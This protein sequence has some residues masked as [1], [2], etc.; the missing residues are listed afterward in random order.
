MW[1]YPWQNRTPTSFKMKTR[2]TNTGNLKR[3]LGAAGNVSFL[4]ALE[5]IWFQGLPALVALVNMRKQ[6]FVLLG[7][8]EPSPG[9]KRTGQVAS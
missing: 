2:I 1:S 4:A 5:A 6:P 3:K 7:G 8:V 9:G